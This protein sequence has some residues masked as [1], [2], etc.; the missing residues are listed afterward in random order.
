MVSG[1]VQSAVSGESVDGA[2]QRSRAETDPGTGAQIHVSVA[3]G[4]AGSRS[5]QAQMASKQP[6]VSKWW[7]MKQFFALLQTMKGGG[8]SHVFQEMREAEICLGEVIPSAED[9]LKEQVVVMAR[10]ALERTYCDTPPPPH[11][12][13]GARQSQT[14]SQEAQSS[15]L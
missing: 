10:H 13:H 11:P 4:E 2:D 6:H 7:K 9:Q 5:E 12:H 8:C 14:Y 15:N 3:T 1:E